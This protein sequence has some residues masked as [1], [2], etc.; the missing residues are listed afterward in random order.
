MYSF[1][2]LFNQLHQ[3]LQ[4]NEIVLT[5]R[6]EPTEEV[7]PRRTPQVD[8][9]LVAETNY[10][11]ST[12]VV[13]RQKIFDKYGITEETDGG[14]N[15]N[16]VLIRD[17]PSALPLL[18]EAWMSPKEL[19]DVFKK[20]PSKW[21]DNPERYVTKRKNP[22]S[23]SKRPQLLFCTASVFCEL[24]DICEECLSH[25]HG[26]GCFNSSCS[27]DWRHRAP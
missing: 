25:L 26:A 4:G 16:H 10:D 11:E 6:L 18:R 9:Q 12:G 24:L 23:K 2:A 21:R 22:N 15:S 8:P 7:S 17:Y 14:L 19:G 20:G 3:L 13:R 27:F 1:D 5:I